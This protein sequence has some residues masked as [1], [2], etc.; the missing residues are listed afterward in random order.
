MEVMPPQAIAVA[1]GAL[2]QSTAGGD[3][4]EAGRAV[5]ERPEYVSDESFAQVVR[6]GAAISPR[7]LRSCSALAVAKEPPA[8]VRF[9]NKDEVLLAVLDIPVLPLVDHERTRPGPEPRRAPRRMQQ[10]RI[11]LTPLNHRW[12]L[13]TLA[14]LSISGVPGAAIATA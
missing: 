2:H 12:H 14:M 13:G 10:I 11:I 8:S 3:C 7:E 5:G 4:P 1:R 6:P 9:L